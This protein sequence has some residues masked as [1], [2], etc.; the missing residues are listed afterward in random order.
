MPRHCV[1]APPPGPCRHPHPSTPHT[2]RPWPHSPPH[3]TLDCKLR[4]GRGLCH[5]HCFILSAYR[6]AWHLTT[7]RGCWLN[8][9]QGQVG[10]SS[11]QCH[12]PH[13]VPAYF[14]GAQRQYLNHLYI[15]GPGTELGTQAK[16]CSRNVCCTKGRGCGGVRRER[17]FLDSFSNGYLCLSTIHTPTKPACHPVPVEGG[18]YTTGVPLP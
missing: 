8:E 7:L 16:K 5:T 17:G 14:P 11:S 10:P 3:S 18:T 2:V 6:K 4:V 13:P 15:P 12:Q 1:S 9:A